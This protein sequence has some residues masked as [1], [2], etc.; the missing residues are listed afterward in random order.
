MI[1]ADVPM[2]PALAA[3]A[4]E[5]QAAAPL[6]KDIRGASLSGPA[7]PRRGRR[8]DDSA[9]TISGRL[10]LPGVPGATCSKA[11]RLCA[12]AGAGRSAGERS[13]RR[14]APSSGLPWRRSARLL[15]VTLRRLTERGLS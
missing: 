5:V 11:G 15:E 3:E 1:L 14:T 9:I 2:T 12:P 6:S 10:P 8:Y 13:R 7:S 4:A